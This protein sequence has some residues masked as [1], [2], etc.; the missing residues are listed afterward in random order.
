MKKIATLNVF[1]LMFL[2]LFSNAQNSSPKDSSRF[3]LS[4]SIP[5]INGYKL[6]FTDSV[7]TSTSFYGLSLGIGYY[8]NNKSYIDLKM[9]TTTSAP[10]PLGG[11][12]LEPPN[13]Y[14][15]FNSKFIDL[16]YNHVIYSFWERRVHYTLGLN[17]TNYSY[18]KHFYDTVIDIT[19][20]SMS[21]NTLG[22]TGGVKFRVFPHFLVGC[23]INSSFYNL[24]K[25]VFEYNHLV[26]LDIILRFGS[27]RD[28]Y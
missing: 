22:I 3:T 18:K 28:N 11:D 15:R 21:K 27:K 4:V 16:T 8:F 9:G 20:Y 2:T 26:Y 12:Y 1:V 7:L 25:G 19:V 10:M 23:K 14:E 5:F 24:S 17:F 6:N 13:Y